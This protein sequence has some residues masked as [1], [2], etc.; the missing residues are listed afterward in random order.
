MNLD[1]RRLRRGQLGGEDGIE[2]ANASDVGVEGSGY[3]GLL[4]VKSSAWRQHRLLHSTDR[5]PLRLANPCTPLLST[6]AHTR[7]P[8]GRRCCGEAT[9]GA[10]KRGLPS[11]P[12]RLRDAHLSLISTTSSIVAFGSSSE[13]NVRCTC[14]IA[15]YLRHHDYSYDPCVTPHLHHDQHTAGSLPSLLSLNSLISP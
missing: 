12:S 10:A 15:T 9:R 4:S 6:R 2:Y 7:S 1:H 13:R 5:H 8:V 3:L 11:E 14:E